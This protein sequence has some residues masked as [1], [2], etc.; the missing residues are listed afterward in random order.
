M[1]EILSQ[2]E[3]DQL[4]SDL[5]EGR[6]VEPPETVAEGPR[7]KR[8]DFK[9][10]NKIPRDQIKTLGIIYENFSRLLGTFLTGTLGVFCEAELVTLE[11]QTFQEFTNSA[12][13]S[14]ILAILGMAPLEGSTLFQISPEIAYAILDCLLGGPGKPSSYRRLFTEIDLVILEKVIKQLLPLLPEAWEKVAKVEAVLE[15]METS[16]QFTQIVPPNETIV[17]ITISVCIGE[18]E[19]LV[20]FC[21]PQLSFEP[22][23]KTLNTR[24]LVS[25]RS[26]PK[27]DSGNSRNILSMISQTSIPIQAVLSEATISVSELVNL[28]IGDV[29]H[30][31][32]H[33]QDPLVIKIGNIARLEGSLGTRGSRYAVKVTGINSKEEADHE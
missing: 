19:A 4:L 7:I 9:T 26:E 15:N 27:N 1:A 17:I 2:N 13:Q 5:N 24:L 14:S 33:Y 32:S 23:T 6:F 25:G 29:I 10:A 18:T 31:D 21:L 20:N 28:Q 11:E 8:Y 16:L 30:L 22:L 3:I 12:P